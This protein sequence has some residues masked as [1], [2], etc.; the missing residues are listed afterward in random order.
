M[1]SNVKYKCSWYISKNVLCLTVSQKY[2]ALTVIIYA[3]LV[4]CNPICVIIHI[5]V[6]III[7]NIV[8]IIMTIGIIYIILIDT[9]GALL[10]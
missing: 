7:I 10:T 4:D 1:C 5:V 2:N 9:A 3:A 8:S 6:A